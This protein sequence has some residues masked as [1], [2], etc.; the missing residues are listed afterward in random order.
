MSLSKH[1]SVRRN[2]G[3]AP[4]KLSHS[5]KFLVKNY[6]GHTPKNSTKKINF[7]VLI[8]CIVNFNFFQL[9]FPKKFYI[10]IPH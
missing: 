1:Y 8:Y 6:I 4:T 2:S 3:F 10:Y 9:N 7:F 5:P